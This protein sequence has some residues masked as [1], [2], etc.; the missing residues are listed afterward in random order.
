M[1]VTFDHFLKIMNHII[2]THDFQDEIRQTISRYN[3]GLRDMCELEMP[4]I[5]EDDLVGLLEIALDD[6]NGW[7]SYWIY[8]LDCGDK[9]EPGCVE[10]ADG[11]DIPLPT[12]ESLWKLLTEESE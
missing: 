12:V 11:N 7:I 8:E 2:L 4:S 1:K 5:M 6:E 9:W 3:E 10:D